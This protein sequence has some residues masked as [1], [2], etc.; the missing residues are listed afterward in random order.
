MDFALPMAMGP[1]SFLRTIW[2]LAPG[3]ARV[4]GGFPLALLLL[5]PLLLSRLAEV[6]EETRSACCAALFVKEHT[7]L[8]LRCGM[9]SGPDAWEHRRAENHLRYRRYR[10]GPS[11]GHECGYGHQRGRDGEHCRR[12]RAGLRLLAPTRDAGHCVVGRAVSARWWSKWHGL[13][14]ETSSGSGWL[15]LI[16]GHALFCPG[17]DFRRG[18]DELAL[19][20][21]SFGHVW[22]RLDSTHR[23]T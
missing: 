6:A 11:K 8:A 17:T 23:V 9:T 12:Q 15:Q 20:R 2:S 14:G 19:D 4:R 5:A 21:V 10:L 1:S 16:R 22:T 18:W 3:S 13:A 7:R